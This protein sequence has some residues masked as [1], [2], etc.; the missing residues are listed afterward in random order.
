MV[1]RNNKGWMR[2]VEVGLAALLIFAFLVFISQTQVQVS[3]ESTD[4]DRVLLK[5]YSQDSLRTFDLK[6]ENGDGKSDLR[7]N[8]IN[9]DW[10]SISDSFAN[11]LPEN[12]GF[13]L[14][15]YENGSSSI[16][17]GVSA[18]NI[19]SSREVITTYYPIAGDYGSFCY[20][21]QPCSLILSVWFKQ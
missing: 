9:D 16:K 15:L 8:I 4:W 11:L 6:D 1:L 13:V 19:P 12:V 5:T 20:S 10:T 17:A 14:Y 21:E 2:V 18:S 7:T 3:E